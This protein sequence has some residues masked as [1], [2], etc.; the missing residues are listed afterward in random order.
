MILLIYQF[1]PTA[2]F[3]VLLLTELDHMTAEAI[4]DRTA[5][6]NAGQVAGTILAA[7]L[8]F[9]RQVGLALVAGFALTIVGLA[10]Y[11]LYPWVDGFTYSTV[12]RTITG[13]GGGILTPVLF[14][15]ALDRMPPPLQ[16]AAGTWLVLANIGGVEIGLALFDM[17]LEISTKLSG[18]KEIGYLT[19][20]VAQLATGLATTLLV[21]GLVA[22]G[23]LHTRIGAVLPRR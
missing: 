14:V 19:V 5:I 16:L 15:L 12:T 18:S 9:K 7:G 8:L 1:P 22:K 6:G 17:V 2:E 20:E 13:L 10:G 11:T 23:R 3:E 4:G 21:F